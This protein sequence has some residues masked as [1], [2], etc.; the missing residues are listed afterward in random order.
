M[1]EVAPG[2]GLNTFVP[3]FSAATGQIQIEFTR[4]PNKFALTRY[5][6]LVPVQQM[7]G[8]YLRIDEEETARVVATQDQIWPLGEDRPTG[9]NTDFDF[10]TYSCSLPVLVSHPARVGS[11]GSVGHRGFARSDSGCEVDD[12]PLY[13]CGQPHQ[14]EHL[15]PLRAA[16]HG[17][18]RGEPRGSLHHRDRAGERQR[19]R[20]QR[21]RMAC[22]RSSVRRARRSCSPPT[23]RSA[24]A[25]SVL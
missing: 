2:G 18:Q 11:S 19:A 17:L 12:A 9:I 7:A 10:V 13:P 24:P 8:Y 20:R 5:A 4:S 22:R 16:L 23:R 21:W 25:T 15:V 1:A 3:T 6:Q 14:H